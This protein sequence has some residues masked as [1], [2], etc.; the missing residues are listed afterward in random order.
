MTKPVTKSDL[1]FA[2][3]RMTGRVEAQVEAALSSHISARATTEPAKALKFRGNVPLA[4]MSVDETAAIA[5]NLELIG[6]YA[7]GAEHFAAAGMSLRSFVESKLAEEHG[8]GMAPGQ[9]YQAR[10]SDA[11]RAALDK[12]SATFAE[13]FHVRSGLLA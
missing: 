2:F 13:R 11:F 12:Q 10:M 3:G 8:I 1:D 9:G 4:A 6:E 7:N 5:E